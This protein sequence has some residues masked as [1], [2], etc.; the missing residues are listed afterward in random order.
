MLVCPKKYSYES[1]FS[2]LQP[3]RKGFLIMLN[4][5][6]PPPP[7]PPKKIKNTA[8]SSVYILFKTN[9]IVKILQRF[10]RNYIKCSNSIF[11]L[12]FIH[13]SAN[14]LSFDSKGLGR[15]HC[16]SLATGS[17][18]TKFTTCEQQVNTM[19]RISVSL[20][21]QTSS[22]LLY[23]KRP[24]KWL[25]SNHWIHQMIRFKTFEREKN[26]AFLMLIHILAVIFFSRWL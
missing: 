17:D 8:S 18:W 10:L 22:L 6:P 21:T 23:W 2:P 16:S 14:S 20:T 9:F 15:N 26:I 24:L 19:S 25:K 5:P 12:V 7:H 1:D 13:Q 3:S 11:I 4:R